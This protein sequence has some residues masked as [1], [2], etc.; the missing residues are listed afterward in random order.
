MS[1]E[2]YSAGQCSAVQCSDMSVERYSAG[3]CAAKIKISSL[4]FVSLMLNVQATL[5]QS[6]SQGP[7]AFTIFSW[8]GA[9]LK[10]KLQIKL[11]V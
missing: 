1:V 4:S 11:I 7:S 8:S 3:Q 10:W 2:R 6:A 9:T 5:M